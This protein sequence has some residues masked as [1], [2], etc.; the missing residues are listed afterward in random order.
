LE[1]RELESA[2]LNDDP[3]ADAAE[4][5]EDTALDAEDLALERL[6][7][8]EE[9]ERED[10]VEFAVAVERA[11]DADELRAEMTEDATDEIELSALL[12]VA[13]AALE[14]R[15]ATM[16]ASLNCML[17]REYK[18]S[19]VNGYG[20]AFRGKF[21]KL[22]DGWLLISARSFMGQEIMLFETHGQ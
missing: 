4:L 20:F 17:F 3:F 16:R 7:E 8:A 11:L 9:A 19:S 13:A 15:A 18:N 21:D 22:V 1:L 12:V 14:A 10:W 6:A 2:E 5:R